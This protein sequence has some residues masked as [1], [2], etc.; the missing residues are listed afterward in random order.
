MKS[1]AVGKGNDQIIHDDEVICAAGVICN[2][3]RYK[4]MWQYIMLRV[5]SSPAWI[6]LVQKRQLWEN[7]V[8]IIL[9]AILYFRTRMMAHLKWQQEL[10]R[11]RHECGFGRKKGTPP[12]N[13]YIFD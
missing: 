6:F 7:N 4:M 11:L 8:L 2:D 5:V 9:P 13:K 1:K 10:R 3:E 12:M